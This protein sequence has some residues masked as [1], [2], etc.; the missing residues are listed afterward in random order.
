MKSFQNCWFVLGVWCFG[1]GWYFFV[2]CVFFCGWH[3]CDV[4]LWWD[5]MLVCCCEFVLVI[6]WF[7]CVFICFCDFGCVLL[8]VGSFGCWIM[9]LFWWLLCCLLVFVLWNDGFGWCYVVTVKEKWWNYIL[10][11]NELLDVSIQTILCVLQHVCLKRKFVMISFVLKLWVNRHMFVTEVF[12]CGSVDAYVWI[13]RSRYAI[14]LLA[15]VMLSKV[16]NTKQ[17]ACVEGKKVTIISLILRS[18][19]WQPQKVFKS[20]SCNGN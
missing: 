20:G 1:C 10:F 16:V 19:W 9:F 15:I 11:E 18:R 14:S 8:G 2:V 6:C 17:A 7:V 13:Q 5:L 3:V 12:D 4:C